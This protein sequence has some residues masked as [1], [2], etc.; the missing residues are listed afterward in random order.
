LHPILSF[1]LQFLFG[2]R[3]LGSVLYFGADFDVAVCGFYVE[4]AIAVGTLLHVAV[5]AGIG[6]VCSLIIVFNIRFIVLIILVGL[7]SRSDSIQKL[8]SISTPVSL[9]LF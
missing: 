9:F 6:L 2:W 1:L 7:L 4:F 5:D 8:L 3:R